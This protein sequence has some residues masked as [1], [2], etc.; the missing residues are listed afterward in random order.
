[1]DLPGANENRL[2]RT[3]RQFEIINRLLTRSRGAIRRYLLRDAV[4]RKLEEVTLLDIGAGGC[5][6]GRWFIEACKRRGIHGRVICLDYDERIVAYARKTCADQPEISVVLGDA[7]ELRRMEEVD[8]V[9][10]NHFLHHL[11][12]E[13]ILELLPMIA[14]K[15]RYGFLLNDLKRSRLSYFGYTCLAGLFLHGSFAFYD[16]RLSIRRGFRREELVT[17][18]EG[19]GEKTIIRSLA[20]GRLLVVGGAL[21]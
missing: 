3:V 2:I 8:Y 18:T 9:F 12:E 17:L 6:I 15:A 21:S 1:M 14:Q 20:P 16:G 19:C 4:A 5:D 7:G 11:P 13:G 10:A